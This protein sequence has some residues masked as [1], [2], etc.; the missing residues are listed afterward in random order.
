MMAAWAGWFESLGDRLADRGNPVFESAELGTRG[1]TVF[2]LNSAVAVRRLQKERVTFTFEEQG[3]VTEMRVTGRLRDRAHT[4][5]TEAL[6]A[7]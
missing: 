3:Q 2:R 4:E 7:D 1:E 6:G 5:L